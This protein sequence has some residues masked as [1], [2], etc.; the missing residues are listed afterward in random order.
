MPAGWT[1]ARLGDIVSII[2]GTSY[3]KSDPVSAGIRIIR[4]G[5]IQDLKITFYD[6][7]IFLP[8]DF[9]DSEKLV[10]NGDI[11][12]V[13]STGSKTLIGK[14]GISYNDFA[15]VQIGVFLRIVRPNDLRLIGYIR[16]IFSSELYRVHIRES[17]KGTNI[18][19]I[20]AEYIDAF[21]IP[22]PP[23][24]EQYRMVTAVERALT[25]LGIVSDNLN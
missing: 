1:V 6:D 4:G 18:N 9:F 20:K 21:M 3:R 11:I 7:D 2:S 22:V 10:K 16:L 12:I 8:D 23:L 13:A 25:E 17:V 15:K 19:N 5:N 24:G 14:P